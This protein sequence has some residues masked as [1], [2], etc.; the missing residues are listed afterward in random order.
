ME[1]AVCSAASTRFPGLP[2]VDAIALVGRIASY[3]TRE[4]I[5]TLGSSRGAS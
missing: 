2:I 1:W 3:L 4:V 5:S